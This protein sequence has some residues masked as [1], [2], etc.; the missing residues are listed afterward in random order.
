MCLCACADESRNVTEENTLIE[1]RFTRRGDSPI[2]ACAEESFSRLID[3]LDRLDTLTGGEGGGAG[4]P[5]GDRA[6]A[7]N[8]AE[9][10]M[11]QLDVA[12]CVHG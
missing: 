2:A 10:V 3:H 11:V 1:V 8:G 7:A 6:G 5:A 4:E 9:E 12:G